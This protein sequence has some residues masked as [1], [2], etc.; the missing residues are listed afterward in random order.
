MEARQAIAAL[1]IEF[2]ADWLYLTAAHKRLVMDDFID[3]NVAEGC[4]AIEYGRRI[5]AGNLG[6]YAK[7]LAA[8]RARL[9]RDCHDTSDVI[10]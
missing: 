7:T 4:S 8:C 6:S 1:E 9:I 2:G 5:G 10:I 3:A